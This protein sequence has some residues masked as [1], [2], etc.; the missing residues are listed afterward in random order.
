[1]IRPRN[2]SDYRREFKDMDLSQLKIALKDWQERW[3]KAF[4]NPFGERSEK[5][6][7]K[8]VSFLK[9]KIERVENIKPKKE[10]KFFKKINI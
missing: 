6:C 5:K 7:W 8:R 1:M 2:R 9:E 4:I 3:D 10:H